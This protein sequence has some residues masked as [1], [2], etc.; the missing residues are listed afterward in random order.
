MSNIHYFQRY[1]TLEN[2]VTN[3]TLHLIARIYE[4]SPHKAGQFLSDLTDE[5]IGLGIKINQQ[6]RVGDAV[7]DGTIIQPSLKLLIEAKVDAKVD[8]E[9]LVRHAKTFGSESLK[10]LL[11]L[12]KQQPKEE[13][14]K[15]SEALQ[16]E[17]PAVIFRWIT[18]KDICDAAS[19]LFKEHES[20]MKSLVEDYEGYCDY[21][22]LF[23]RSEFFMRVVPCG[24]SAELNSN[25]GIYFQPSDRGYSK[26]KYVGIYREKSVRAIIEVESVFDVEIIDGKLKKNP[27]GESN[28]TSDYDKKI[29]DIVEEAR[30]KCGYDLLKGHRFFCGKVAPTDFKKS[31][32]GGIQ[33]ARFIDFRDHLEIINIK[34][35]SLEELAK[36]LSMPEKSWE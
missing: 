8:A 3:N 6:E 21:A 13:E 5:D 35:Q 14:K 1:S 16:L 36:A 2:T 22:G 28:N 34:S 12:T 7:P 24:K 27:F 25:Y 20:F 33:G 26:H 15:I 9:Q 10:I 31:T 11:L 29:L 19:K 23:D 30:I 32:K 4:Y 18:Y 17:F